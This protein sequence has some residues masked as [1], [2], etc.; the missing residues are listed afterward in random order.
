MAGDVA[1]AGMAESGVTQEAAGRSPGDRELP[2]A[3][4]GVTPA[5]GAPASRP[6]EQAA[7]DAQAA[8]RQRRGEG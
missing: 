5:V 1:T 6:D 3:G 7:P 4:D 2:V 8:V